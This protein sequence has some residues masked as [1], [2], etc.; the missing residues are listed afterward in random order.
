[1]L[2]ALC[3]SQSAIRNPRPPRLS[4]LMLATRPPRLKPRDTGRGGGQAKFE[5]RSTPAPLIS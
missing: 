1:M 3:L 4:E 2:S 5:I